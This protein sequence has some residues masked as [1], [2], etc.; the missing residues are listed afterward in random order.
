MVACTIP[1]Q[2]WAC[3]RGAG[4]EGP[5][6]AIAHQAPVVA[7][8]WNGFGK[9]ALAFSFEPGCLNINLAGYADKDGDGTLCFAD[10]ALEW[11]TDPETG[12]DYRW[13]SLPNSE[14]LALRDKLNE[15]FPPTHQ[16][17]A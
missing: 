13:V 16:V 7:G 6:A 17:Q 11:E 1:P 2:G 15:V 14:L 9:Y 3:T 4:H 10:S 12:K 8:H 5:C